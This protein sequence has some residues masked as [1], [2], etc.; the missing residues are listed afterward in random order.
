MPNTH[1]GAPRPTDGDWL[2]S[3]LASAA[4][5]PTARRAARRD[6][7]LGAPATPTGHAAGIRGADGYAGGRVQR[8]YRRHHIAGAVAAALDGWHATGQTS[9]IDV[10]LLAVGRG[11]IGPASTSP[12]FT[13]IR[14]RRSTSRRR[15][16]ATR[17][18][19]PSDARMA[20]SFS[21]RCF[22]PLATGLPVWRLFGLEACR[23]RAVRLARVVGGVRR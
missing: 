12:C 23:G 10:S 11:P 5:D 8:Q 3:T 17:S 2:G 1:T 7:V 13:A 22:S 20:A 19:E 21:F 6:G 16:R 18:P 14:C 9:V 15:R 4:K